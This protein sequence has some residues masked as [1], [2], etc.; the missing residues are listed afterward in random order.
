MTWYNMIW[1]HSIWHV[2]TWRQMIDMTHHTIWQIRWP[3]RRQET[4]GICY[5]HRAVA[6]RYIR[7]TIHH[8]MLSACALSLLVW[9]PT[10]HGITTKYHTHHTTSLNVPSYDITLNHII[11]SHVF[12]SHPI[13]SHLILSHNIPF[14]PI[15]SYLILSHRMICRSWTS[16]RTLARKNLEHVIY[17][18]GCGSLI[19]SWKEWKKTV[20]GLSCV[21]QSAQVIMTHCFGCIPLLFSNTKSQKP[22]SKCLLSWKLMPTNPKPNFQKVVVWEIHHHSYDGMRTT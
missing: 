5:L 7:G 16:V 2:I 10:L 15:P 19:C 8:S 6:C 12:P 21:L 22:N 1:Y 18:M 14:G 17:F 20:N 3:R 13:S 4:R 9:S 11:S